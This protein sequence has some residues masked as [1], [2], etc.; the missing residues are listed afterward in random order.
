MSFRIWN[1]I[2]DLGMS[3]S[4]EHLHVGFMCH[5]WLDFSIAARV[6]HTGVL[7]TWSIKN[8]SH[9]IALPEDLNQVFKLGDRFLNRATDSSISTCMDVPPLGRAWPQT[10]PTRRS[11]IVNTLVF[12]DLGVTINSPPPVVLVLESV[13][14]GKL[15]R[16]YNN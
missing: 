8:T 12:A 1:L 3:D 11:W 7:D 13:Q 4:D 5:H 6:L 9:T 15:L 16:I 2:A 14:V 10:Q